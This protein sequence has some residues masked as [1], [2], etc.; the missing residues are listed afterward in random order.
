MEANARHLERIFDQTIQYQVPLFQRPYVWEES[1]NWEPLWEDIETLLSKQITQ[2]KVHPHF[3]GAVVLEQLANATGKIESRQVIDGQQRFTT[4]QLFLIAC[5]DHAALL[6]SERFAERFGDLVSNRQNRID[7]TDEAFKVWPTNSDRPAYRLVHGSGSVKE[8]DLRLKAEPHMRESKIVGAY[9]YF[10]KQIDQW[11]KS[12][13]GGDSEEATLTLTSNDRLDALWS[14][15][16]SCLL[17]VVIDLEK[18]DEAQVIFETMNALGEPLL[19]ADL[20]KNYL[21]RRATAEEDDVEALYEK[22]WAGFDDDANGWRTQVKQGR[23]MRNR[24]DIFVNH[25]LSLMIQDDVRST[26]L[27]NAFKSFVANVKPEEGS[28]IPAP[29]TAAGHMQQLARYAKIYHLFEAPGAHHRLDQFMK[30]LDAIDTTTVYPFLL[31]AYDKLMP[32]HQDEFDQIL[33]V[34]EAF[35]VRRLV[36]GLTP[37]NYNRYFIDLIKWV[38]KASELSVD[39]V[40]LWLARSKGDSSRFPADEEFLK[41]VLTRPIYRYLKGGKTRMLLEAIDRQLQHRKSEALP[42]PDGLTVEHVLPQEWEANWPLSDE[43]A[44]DP[45]R[46]RDATQLRDQMLQTLGNLTLVTDSLNPALSNA[47]WAIKRPELLKYSKLNL[48]Q[49]FH[50]A[51]A[52]VWDEHAILERSKALWPVMAQIWPDLDVV[53]AMKVGNGQRT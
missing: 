33:D 26:H 53:A 12:D 42:L 14:V 48:A 19:P 18:E 7:H 24:V 2:V 36:C 21:F 52:D 1:K 16:K 10:F 30:R 22:Y 43:I 13:A 32:D 51:K 17:V 44:R 20:I 8:L 6:G 15:A 23:I 39:A 41:A 31:L 27:F 5:R 45:V 9:R 46:L 29:T 4:L 37:K 50:E 11:L 25:Y 49:Y 47:A 34:I 3:L 40:S 28:L 35:L 38:D